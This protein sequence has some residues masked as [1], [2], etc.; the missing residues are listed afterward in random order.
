MDEYFAVCARGVEEVSAAE[1][2]RLGAANVRPGLGGVHF[3]GDLALLYKA[4]LWLRTVTRILR[5]LREFAAVTQEMLYSQVRRIEWEKYLNPQMTFA[6]HATM[7]QAEKPRFEQKTKPWGGRNQGRRGEEQSGGQGINH[8]G[9]AALKTKDAIVDRLRREQGARPNVDRVN[10]NVVVHVHFAQRRCTLSLDSTGRSLHERGYREQSTEAPMK[11]TLAA[12][13]IEMTG[14]DGTVPFY[15]P[16]CGSGTLVIEAALKALNIAPGLFRESFAFERWP[17]FDQ[18]L[19]NDVREETR[20]QALEAP[21]APIAGSDMNPGAIAA[22]RAN[23][24]TAG[25][26]EDVQ[27]FVRKME[28]AQPPTA[29]PGVLLINPPY[30][31]RLG[32]EVALRPLYHQMGELFRQRF[33]GWRAFVFAGNLQLARHIELTAT[34]KIKLYN[35]PLVCRLLE[36]DLR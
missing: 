15:D 23:A 21:R 9:F 27:L 20:H 25:I 35:G 14:W 12:A 24:Q 18:K 13:I 30:G 1:L 22:A 33:Q 11:E 2:M 28:E 17:D 26:D 16:M 5:P 36:F 7:E 10:P 31:T 6:V 29:E 3:E 19:W 32:D 8:T 4:N 34:R